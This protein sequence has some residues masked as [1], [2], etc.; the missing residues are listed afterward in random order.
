MGP[1]GKATAQGVAGVLLGGNAG[2]PEGLAQQRDHAVGMQPLLTQVAPAIDPAKQRAAHQGR[3]TQPFAI[4]L[5]RAQPQQRRGLIGL[6]E[7]LAVAL[8]ARQVQ[9]DA[10]AWYR[11]DMLDL[12]TAQLIT[13]KA[14]PKAQQDQGRVALGTQ[15][16]RSI[17]LC[18]RLLGITL[19]PADHLLQMLELQ[20]FGLFFLGRV[21][22]ADALEH[23]AH[24]RR[25][26]RIGKTLAGVPLRQRREPQFQRIDREHPGI[27]HQV[28][29]HAVAG[30]GQEAAP[31]HLKVLDGSAI[32]ATG[33]IAG[34]GVQVSI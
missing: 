3:G 14:A 10:R 28:S 25:L 27:G 21:Q 9:G 4:G 5:Y 23:L 13:A 16:A 17:A 20:G 22:G 6:A 30:G 26:G 11:L 15:P 12:Q 34:G 2:P 29:R 8:A 32:A 19:K 33:V 18:P 7:V 1:G 31:T 24:H